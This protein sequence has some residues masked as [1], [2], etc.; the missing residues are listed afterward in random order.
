MLVPEFAVQG[1]KVA[2]V[3]PDKNIFEIV[4]N[5]FSYMKSGKKNVHNWKAIKQNLRLMKNYFQLIIIL[6][7]DYW[8]LK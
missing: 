5:G 8:R 3:K 7:N 1:T 2:K 6:W 4:Q